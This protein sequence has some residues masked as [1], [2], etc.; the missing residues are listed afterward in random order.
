MPQYII[1][2]ITV[3]VVLALSYALNYLLSRMLK[4]GQYK[5]V[6]APGVIIHEL[7]HAAAAILTGAQIQKIK[8]FGSSGGHVVHTQSR[9]PIAGQ[10]IISFAPLFG[11]TLTLYILG[12]LL[13]P[14]LIQL[15]FSKIGF[16]IISLKNLLITTKNNLTQLKF[17]HWQ[18]WIFIYAL[19]SLTASMAPSL[20]D[21]R[22]T[23]L[24]LVVLYFAFWWQ[25]WVI[26]L[27]IIIILELVRG[28]W[29]PLI[30]D[31]VILALLLLLYRQFG[32][33][34]V[35]MAAIWGFYLFSIYL[36][37]IVTSL[38]IIIFGLLSWVKK[39]PKL[40]RGYN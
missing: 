33:S 28:E 32:W 2:L 36:L 6:I 16:D 29:Q 15:D 40:S 26:L 37:A 27:G 4:A 9:I 3:A 1:F 5:I 21:L 19:L 12:K 10:A 17:T 8:L 11:A 25:F 14:E 13:V 18:T 39:G 34:T 24:G 23:L 20:T 30:I 35:N 22:N 31:L 38:S 7:S